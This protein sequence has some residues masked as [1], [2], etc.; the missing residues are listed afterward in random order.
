[1]SDELRIPTKEDI[2]QLP[3]WAIVAF[4]ARCARRVQPLFTFAWADAPKEHIE[5]IDLAII[6][7]ERCA[8]YAKVA[9]ALYDANT[10]KAAYAAKAA[11]ATKAAYATK[12]AAYAVYAARAAYTAYAAD[13][14]AYDAKAPAYA[15]KAAKV[16]ADAAYTDANALIRRDF[17]ILKETAEREHWTDNTPVPQK[18]FGPMWPDGKPTGWF[19]SG[20]VRFYEQHPL[21]I[22][23]D[24]V[25]ASKET[26]R[27][28]FEA[29]SD[30]H[31]AAGGL[32]LE[33]SSDGYFTY[34]MESVP[35]EIS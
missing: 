24:P 12:A 29:I 23:I 9:D 16:A 13:A 28:V 10:A 15:A 21:E 14:A 17:D 20:V 3:R 35:E 27:S 8:T 6:V 11:D 25:N 2:A 5:A 34:A 31:I 32:G 7:A 26:I 19:D 30:W 22:Y 1:M 33:F 18:V 4:A